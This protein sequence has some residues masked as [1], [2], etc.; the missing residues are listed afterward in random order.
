MKTKLFI[1]LLAITTIANAQ[2]TKM[3]DFAGGPNGNGP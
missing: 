2:F 1:A 3:F